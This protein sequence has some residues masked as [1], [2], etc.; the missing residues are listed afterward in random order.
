[1]RKEVELKTDDHGQ[2]RGVRYH[3]GYMVSFA[4]GQDLTFVIRA[5]DDSLTELLLLDVKLLC[6]DPIW[7]SAII[8]DIDIWRALEAPLGYWQNLF[9]G[10]E[11]S[12]GLEAQRARYLP[13]CADYRLVEI[14]TAYGGGFTCLCS[15]VQIF[16]TEAKSTASSP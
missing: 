5:T 8:T 2:L 10:R 14:G 3:D 9:R 15:H 6:T 7:E 4:F 13:E 12:R 16:Q 11:D 1:M